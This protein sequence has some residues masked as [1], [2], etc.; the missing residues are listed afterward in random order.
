[1]KRGRFRYYRQSFLKV[2][3]PV[4]F[5]ELLNEEKIENDD[6]F[7]TL[8]FVTR[9]VDA[10]T[11]AVHLSIMAFVPVAFT[12]KHFH[13]CLHSVVLM[14]ELVCLCSVML[15]MQSYFREWNHAARIHICR[16]TNSSSTP[17]FLPIKL[18]WPESSVA[19]YVNRF[20]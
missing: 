15:Q 12:D 20:L 6:V 3:E 16:A 17:L 1:M 2:C 11:L 13:T 19:F 7:R 9:K 18:S 4:K 5:C 8:V 14:V 10:D